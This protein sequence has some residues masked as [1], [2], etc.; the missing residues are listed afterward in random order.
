MVPVKD[1]SL[2]FSTKFNVYNRMLN[3]RIKF[4][5]LSAGGISNYHPD[6]TGSLRFWTMSVAQ[7]S[8]QLENTLFRKTEQVSSIP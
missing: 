8:K 4:E 1:K 6:P 2:N 3:P 5:F 7:N